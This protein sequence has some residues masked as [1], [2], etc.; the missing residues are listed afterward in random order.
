[1]TDPS[2]T[3]RVE[4]A[5]RTEAGRR[6]T[7]AA[8]DAKE[9]RA[10][11]IRKAVTH[12]TVLINPRLSEIDWGAVEDRLSEAG[13]LGESAPV[14]EALKTALMVSL[15]EHADPECSGIPDYDITADAAA[16]ITEDVMTAPI[17]VSALAALPSTPQGP[18]YPD[19]GPEGPITD[20]NGD[21][22]DHGEQPGQDG[23]WTSEPTAGLR[24]ALE[25]IVAFEPEWIDAIIDN[26]DCSDC[27]E[28]AARRWPPSGLCETHYRVLSNAE[29]ANQDRRNRMGYDLKDI[30]R[31]ALHD[32]SLQAPPPL[33]RERPTP[34]RGLSRMTLD[35]LRDYAETHGV[36]YWD[37]DWTRRDFITALA[38]SQPTG[39]PA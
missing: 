36:R 4:E 12:S 23:S 17:M 5:P 34:P 28:V 22:L 37:G 35:Q 13:R 8:L 6:L 39:D 21:E 9:R 7:D 2:R 11:A 33:D 14:R 32:P 30:A 31:A 16:R 24:V 3:P 19:A 29:R 18:T 10:E 38:A 27:A 25:Q 15:H 26:A 20:A 1:M